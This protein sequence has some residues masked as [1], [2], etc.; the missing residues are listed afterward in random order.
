MIPMAVAMLDG[1]VHRVVVLYPG[2]FRERHETLCGIVYRYREARETR[3]WPVN[4]PTC[5]ATEAG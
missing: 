3:R 1:V 2:Q 4:C 5:L